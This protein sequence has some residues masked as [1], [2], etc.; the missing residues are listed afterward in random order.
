[1]K[2]KDRKKRKP[3]GGRFRDSTSDITEKISA[4]IHFDSRLYDQDIGGSIAHAKMLN[5][6]GILSDDEMGEIVNGLNEIRREVAEGEFEFS[7][8]LEDIHMNIEAVLIERIG[9]TGRKL[10]TARSRN[11]QIALDLRLYIREQSKRIELLIGNLISLLLDLAEV[12]IDVVMPGYT[13]V[14]IAQPVRFSHYLLAHTW[15]LLRDYERLQ[16]FCKIG[17]VLPLGA[18][19]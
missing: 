6:I 12:H 8:S 10:H 3:W 19:G 2:S 15:P 18:G 4:S 7:A 16:F 17:N 1:M 11:D 14:Q 5:R 13:H 9:D